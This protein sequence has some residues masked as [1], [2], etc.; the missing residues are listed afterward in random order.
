MKVSSVDKSLRDQISS[1]LKKASDKDFS[2]FMDMAKRENPEFY[3]KEMYEKIVK[4]GEKIKTAPNIQSI[5]EYKQYISE[6]LTFILKNCYRISKDYSMFSA[7]LLTRV[8]V[9]N[10]KVEELVSGF[11]EDQKE[12]IKLI[13]TVDEISGLL[14][15]L[16]N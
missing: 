7:H 12:G 3:L 13:K 6:Y 2:S 16:Y 8:D 10:K 9:I 4:L 1:P 15:D 14:L 11:L 5:R